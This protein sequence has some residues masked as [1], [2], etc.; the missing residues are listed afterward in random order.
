MAVKVI[1][2]EPD[3]SVVKRIVCKHCGATLEYLPVDV[4][5]KSWSCMTE[6]CGCT[7]VVCPQCSS[8]VTIRS[9]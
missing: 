8:D 6:P 1:K 3:A 5:E 7:Y 9:W 2:T 4:K